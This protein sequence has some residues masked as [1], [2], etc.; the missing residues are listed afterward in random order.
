MANTPSA[1]ST[2]EY[3]KLPS[4]DALLHRPEVSDLIAR[5]GAEQVT[6]AIRAL[7]DESRAA[8]QRGEAAPSETALIDALAAGLERSNQPSLRA[9]I[10]ATG[11]IIHTNLGRA[12][13]STAAR[14]AIAAIA[15]GYNNLEYDVAAG[16][17]GS[18]HTHA[19]QLLRELTGAQDALVVNNNAG[20]VFLVL[21]ALC[22]GR[23]VVISRGEL[24]EI[25]GGFRI[26]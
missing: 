18:R 15:T 8:I 3:R 17:R 23:E 16:E 13:L 22:A 24:V 2:A 19:R 12:P 14:Q 7:L 25:G 20:A 11:V 26:P 10:N 4:V 6:D 21:S 9:V 5:Y 1:T